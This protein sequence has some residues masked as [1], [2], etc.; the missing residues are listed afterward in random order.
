M[1]AD[2]VPALIHELTSGEMPILPAAMANQFGNYLC[3]RLI[4]SSGETEIRK[5]INV[6]QDHVFDISTSIH[7][8]RTMQTLAEVVVKFPNCPEVAAFTRALERDVLELSMHTHGNHVIQ[9]ILVAFRSSDKPSDSDMPGTAPNTRFTDFV[10]QACMRECRLI[11]THKHGCCVLQRCLEKGSWEQ[12]LALADVIVENL[13]TLIEDQFGNYLVQNVLKLRSEAKNEMIFN[14][15]A[16]DFVRLSQLKFSSNVI[17][18]CLESD[19]IGRQI[20]QVFR[21]T[22]ANEDATV[23]KSLG[24]Q[25]KKV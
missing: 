6:V 14:A 25:A 24:K 21:G 7:G 23:A 9:A 3:Q 2:F 22:H 5:I 19:N 17:E 12:K 1:S 10:F 11:G 4:E 18:K 20:E 13:A 15:I 8:T 16:R